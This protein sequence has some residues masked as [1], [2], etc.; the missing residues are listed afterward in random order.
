[1]ILRNT[2][3]TPGREKKRRSKQHT[4]YRRRKAKSL[5]VIVNSLLI[6]FL[7]CLGA[8]AD[9]TF[10]LGKVVITA[11]RTPHLLKEVPSSVTVITEEEIASSSADNIGEILE[12]VV[13]V[14]IKSYGTNG[15]A[16][17]SIRGST[18]SQVLIFIDGRPI[19]QASSGTADLSLYPLVG[20]ERIEVV[21][22][23]F[24]SLYGTGALGGV[25]NIITQPC[26]K[27]S[28]TFLQASY[29]SLEHKLI[30]FSYGGTRNALGYLIS[31]IGDAS[32]G[33]IENS[34]KDRLYFSGKLSKDTDNS[35]KIILSGGYTRENRGCP[36]AINYPTPQATQKDKIYWGDITYNG[37][38]KEN[39]SFSL[40]TYFSGDQT[41]YE[42]PQNWTGL[43][44][45][46]TKNKTLG[47][48]FQHNFIRSKIHHLSWGGEWK[49]DI[50]NVLTK[51][52][53]S[54]IG[55]EKK[56]NLGALFIQ[57]E[58]DASSNTDLVISARYDD[59]SVYGSQL[60]PRV[61]LL[62]NP[63]YKTTFRLSYGKGFRAPTINDLYWEEDWGWGS[64]LFGNPDLKPEKSSGYEVGCEH[65]FSSRFLGRV[66][67]YRQQVD[68]LIN[69]TE[70]SLWRWESMN[71][72]KS[73]LKG[74]EGEI[75]V[76][77]FSPVSVSI[78][79]T[80]L[81]ATDQKEYKGKFL[82]Y[83]PQHSASWNLV[84]GVNK[85]LRLKINGQIVGKRY[86]DREN[87]NTLS[88]YSLLGFDA[89]W[90]IKKNLQ[91]FISG[92]NILNEKYEQIQYN[93]LPGATYTGGVKINF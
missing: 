9:E 15:L 86:T 91:I 11:T 39:S 35:S 79:Y 56:Q 27:E 34:D 6:L 45:D 65:I 22:G 70:T 93:P 54:R 28:S 1:M 89:L 55:G 41:V 38:L 47:M 80:Y 92:N 51:D 84:Y 76:I 85:P 90:K 66:S 46:T 33:D 3:E 32:Q 72:D 60:S 81:K 31:G 53:S 67:F 24:S 21:R 73:E 68:D 4:V 10:D 88:P 64:G 29:G 37:K 40:K 16:I 78:N 77:P 59:H 75:K 48:I 25:I 42:N 18:S 20:I 62:L 23:P 74:W 36:G 63:D 44:K 13:G 69:W 61:N 30:S 8:Q 26:P 12:Q 19:N 57:D 58:I 52:G 43:Q 50:V 87:L 82:T 17:A 2:E 49:Q 5:G 7:V 14:E 83:R 71:V